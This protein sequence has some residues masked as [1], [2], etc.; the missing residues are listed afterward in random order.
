MAGRLNSVEELRLLRERLRQDMGVRYGP[1]PPPP[2]GSVVTVRL[3]SCGISVGA[4][5]VFEAFR[6]EISRLGLAREVKLRKTGC[7]GLCEAEP[8]VDVVRPGLPIVTYA[9]VLPERVGRIIRDHI[10][11]GTVIWEWIVEGT[12][13]PRHRRRLSPPRPRRE[14]RVKP[15]FLN[16]RRFIT[17]GVPT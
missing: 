7:F 4:Y 8:L 3:G 11:D 10:I 17:P 13:R 5:E 6:E 14:N 2:Q 16:I 1:G 15:D 12:R 9:R